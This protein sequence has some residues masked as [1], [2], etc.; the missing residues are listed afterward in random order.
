MALYKWVMR[1]C[2]TIQMGNAVLRDDV[3]HEKARTDRRVA[4]RWWTKGWLAAL[5][6]LAM[7]C[8]EDAPPPP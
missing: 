5:L 1:Y 8:G 3:S 4:D 6:P 2:A 7:G